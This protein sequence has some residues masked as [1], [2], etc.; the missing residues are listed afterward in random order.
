MKIAHTVRKK[1]ND[2]PQWDATMSYNVSKAGIDRMRHYLDV[3]VESELTEVVF[4]TDNSP[5]LAYRIREA[6]FSVQ[7]YSDH[8]QYHNLRRE[9]RVFVGI[10][11]VTC[12]RDMLR[13][14]HFQQPAREIGTI[15]LAEIILLTGVIGAAIRF[16]IARQLVF[17]NVKLTHED[18]ARLYKWTATR[19]WQ[20]IDHMGEG[21][22]LTKNEIDEDLLWSPE[23]E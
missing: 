1:N 13:G 14:E 2:I 19:D 7:N 22:T 4:E 6:M 23:D 3:L 10:G 15:H 5:Q 17:P 18:K 20:Y 8:S 21:L 12:R 9:Y 11:A 16:K